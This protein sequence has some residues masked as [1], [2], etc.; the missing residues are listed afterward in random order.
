[1]VGFLLGKW[2]KSGNKAV[3]NRPLAHSMNLPV[4]IMKL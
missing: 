3:M 4:L 1:L 2:I